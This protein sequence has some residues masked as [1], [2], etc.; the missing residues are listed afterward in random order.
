[1]KRYYRIVRDR[2]LGY[3]VQWR[4]WWMPFWVQAS[5][6]NTHSTIEKAEEFARNHARPQVKYL[7]AL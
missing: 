2:W 7:G 6:S 3:E 5:F 1:M 4:Y